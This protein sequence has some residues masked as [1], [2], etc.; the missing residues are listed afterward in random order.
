MAYS[1]QFY[2]FPSFSLYL[3]V[4]NSA[5]LIFFPISYFARRF[6]KFLTSREF[7]QP[8]PNHI[9]VN[10]SRNIPDSFPFLIITPLLFCKHFEIIQNQNKSRP[11]NNTKVNGQVKSTMK[12]TVGQVK[13]RKSGIQSNGHEVRLRWLFPYLILITEETQWKFHIGVLVSLPIS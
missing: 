9:P 8:I 4:H 3:L 6:F 12:Q 10:F 5:F 1:H 7:N 2:H 13:L 11:S